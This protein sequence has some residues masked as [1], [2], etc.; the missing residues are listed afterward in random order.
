MDVIAAARSAVEH[1]SSS[2][3]SYGMLFVHLA[4]LMGLREPQTQLLVLEP[5]M[6]ASSSL[7]I[8][9][10]TNGESGMKMSTT[11][12]EKRVKIE[13]GLK[14]MFGCDAVGMVDEI[15]ES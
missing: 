14:W 5:S 11:I 1:L 13:D 7:P 6:T 10:V 9:K 3:P 4:S 8:L 15:R 2:N 12:R